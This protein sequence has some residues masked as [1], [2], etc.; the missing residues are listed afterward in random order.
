MN[1]INAEAA[2][3]IIYVLVPEHKMS[4]G[5]KPIFGRHAVAFQ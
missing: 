5:R 2:N 1:L 3:C 4:N